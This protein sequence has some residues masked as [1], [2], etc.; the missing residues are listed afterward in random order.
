M[1]AEL[2]RAIS[3]KQV[4]CMLCAHFCRLKPGERGKCGVRAA[5]ANSGEPFLET[6]VHELVAARNVDPIEKK[7]LYHYLPGSK[8]YSFGTM[9]CNLD[10]AWCQNYNISRHPA[11]T[12][13]V[14]GVRVNPTQIVLDA[15]EN[16]CQSI[17]FTYTEPTVF[18]ELMIKIA[19]LA[20]QKSLGRVLVSNGFQSPDCLKGLESRIDAANIDLKSFREK[21]YEKYCSARLKP[22]LDNLKTMRNFGWLLEVTTLLIPTIND[23]DEE[24]RDMTDF[25]YTELGPDTPWHISAFRPCRNLINIPPT[26]LSILNKAAEIGL[27]RGLNYV[28]IGNVAQGQSRHTHCPACKKMVISRNGFQAAPQT[29]FAGNCPFCKTAIPGIWG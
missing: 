17:A 10:C 4:Q 6:L 7:P 16:A 20:F 12:G 21:T 9:G 2:F 25:I 5:L 27:T 22:V 26:S 11:E 28:Y 14:T 13:Q 18:Y 19:D 3:A 1:K 15:L 8:V 23:S 24:L 29:G